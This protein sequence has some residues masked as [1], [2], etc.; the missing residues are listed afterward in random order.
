MFLRTNAMRE[1][2]HLMEES[3]KLAGDHLRIQ[4]GLYE[5][6]KRETELKATKLQMMERDV[7]SREEI[8][9]AIRKQAYAIKKLSDQLIEKVSFDFYPHSLP[10]LA[11]DLVYNRLSLLQSPLR[12]LLLS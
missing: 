12:R 8:A 11:S 7:N 4:E 1:Q 10:L 5:L 2:V 3:N 9:K 6:R